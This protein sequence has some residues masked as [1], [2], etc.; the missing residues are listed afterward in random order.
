MT[1][2][3]PLTQSYTIKLWRFRYDRIVLISALSVL[4]L[5]LLSGVALCCPYNRRQ[6]PNEHFRP[7]LG[8]K[9]AARTH[10]QRGRVRGIRQ[11]PV[12]YF[13]ACGWVPIILTQTGTHIPCLFID[14]GSLCW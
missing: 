10:L 9:P 6:L 4:L 3:D 13:G 11:E 7:R 2:Y 14:D 1:G 8:I 12:R 5:L